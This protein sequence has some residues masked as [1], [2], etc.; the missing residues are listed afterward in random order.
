MHC[1]VRERELTSFLLRINN[2]GVMATPYG[3]T[4]DGF[5]TQLGICHIAHFLLFDLVKPLLLQSAKASGSTSR[6]INLSSA[7]HRIAPINFDA[8][9][10]TEATYNPYAA[11][12]A[13][14]TANILMTNAITRY[15]GSQGLT[16]LAVHPGGI[17]ATGLWKTLTVEELKSMGDGEAMARSFKSPAQGAATTVWA[18]VS[19]RFEDV[20]NGGRFLGDAGECRAAKE[21]DAAD[22]PSYAPWAYDVESEDRLW[23][24]SREMLG[25]GAE[26]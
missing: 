21:D 4:E 12:G 8:P 1:I 17:P 24:M 3:L 18:A 23:N 9:N 19:P 11:Y 20:A 7:G 2:A 22:T 26:E 14:K 6:V 25:L 5:E 10:F 13:A 15:Y 16:G